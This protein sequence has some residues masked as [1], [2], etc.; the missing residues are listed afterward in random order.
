MP[1]VSG[2]LQPIIFAGSHQVSQMDQV[3]LCCP[4]VWKIHKAAITAGSWLLQG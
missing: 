2:V 3:T 4:I 1:A